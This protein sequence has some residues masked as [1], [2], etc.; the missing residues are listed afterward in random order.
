M[1]TL[2]D[3]GTTDCALQQMEKTEH[4]VWLKLSRWFSDRGVD[5][6]WEEDPTGGRLADLT[7]FETFR[8][9]GNDRADLLVVGGEGVFVVEVKH[10]ENTSSVN[11]GFNQTCEYWLD[12]IRGDTTYYANGSPV[13]VD[14]FVLSTGFSP[15]GS[16]FA[17]WHDRTVRDEPVEKRWMSWAEPPIHCA[18]DW[19]YSVSESAT[20]VLWEFAKSNISDAAP[21][22][23]PGIGT[24]LSSVLD[25]DQQPQRP[26][27]DAVGPFERAVSEDYKPMAC[28]K[29]P[30]VNAGSGPSCH[31]WGWVQ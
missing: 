2:D 10:G 12:Y 7:Q 8:A 5:V 25:S 1:S 4:K 14:A 30:V 27:V 31:N 19:E 26:S 29:R 22:E 24:V 20:R 16:V 21:H 13:D 6:F 17:R 11:K 3:F 9:S 18:P 15:D 28:Y 23:H